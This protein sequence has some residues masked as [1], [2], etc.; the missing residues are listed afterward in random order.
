M[1]RTHRVKRTRK[2]RFS[3]RRTMRNGS[4]SQKGRRQQ[5]RRQQGRRQQG[6]R[7]QGGGDSSVA[8]PIVFMPRG[9]GCSRGPM[10]KEA[11]AKF[12]EEGDSNSDC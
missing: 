3:R 9:P 6:R 8:T 12:L 10:T 11:A 1:K 4:K 7:Q 2:A 5:G